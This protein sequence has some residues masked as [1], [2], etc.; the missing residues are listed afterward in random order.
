MSNIQLVQ[1]QIELARPDFEANA[2]E[3]KL[4]LSFQKEA[5]FALQIFQGND[6][7]TKM[8]PD[9]IKNAIVNVALTGLTLNPVM[10]FAYLVPRKGKFVL[11]VSYMGLAKILTDTGSVKK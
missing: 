10:K 7:L 4:N 9:S 3:L 1:Q 8:S 6:Y 2:A 11:D 5:N